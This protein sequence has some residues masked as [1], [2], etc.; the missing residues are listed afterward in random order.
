MKGGESVTC[1]WQCR[2]VQ[3][4]PKAQFPIGKERVY[5][6][7]FCDMPGHFLKAFAL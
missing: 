7:G 3:T 1:G 5:V 4:V 6:W 2:G